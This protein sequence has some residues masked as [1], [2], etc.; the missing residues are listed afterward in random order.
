MTAALTAAVRPDDWNLPLFIHLAGAFVLVGAMVLA[1]TALLLTWRSGPVEMT[2]LAY[3]SLLWGAIP[4]W[5]VMRVGAQW[6]ASKE[7]VEDAEFAWIEIGY[8]A[9]EPTLLL[10]IAATVLTGRGIARADSEGKRR[11][12]AATVL[13]GLVLVAYVVAIWAM[14]T[15]PV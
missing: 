6:I 12:P 5:I 9:S 3:R 7:G 14:T 4:S 11:D 15:K 10:L 13:V 2:K 1:F 8:I